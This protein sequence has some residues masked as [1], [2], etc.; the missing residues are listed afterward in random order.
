MYPFP[1]TML[2]LSV[3]VWNA[4]LLAG[5]L[6]G[7]GILYGTFR[8]TGTRQVP[9]A[10]LVR[11]VVA[12]Y[13]A[14]IGAQ[15][16]A[17][18]FDMNTSALPPRGVSWVVY[19][20]SPVA[21]P[22]TLYGAIVFLPIGG[23]LSAGG[24]VS[25]RRAID[26]YAPALMVVMGMARVG[27]LLQGCCYGVCARAVGLTFAPGSVVY[28]RH[29]HDELIT[30]G[31]R[32]LPVVPTQLIAAVALFT[33][34]GWSYGRLRRGAPWVMMDGV[35]AYSVFRFLIELV[36]ADPDRNLYASLSTSQ[37]IALGILGAYALTWTRRRSQ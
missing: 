10:L 11:Y 8:T 30:E 4:A 27:C 18:L 12:A 13:V 5:V 33:L 6:V 7:Y 37:W 21:G 23:M 2:G 25:V 15:L 29:L 1:V 32:S 16:F 14:V 26:A 24:G 17:Y 22:K 28:F 35:A 20:L 19:Y 34:A 31:S 36:R 3:S 9:R